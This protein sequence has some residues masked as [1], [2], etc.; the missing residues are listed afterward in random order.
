MSWLTYAIR[1]TMRTIFPSCV[2]G[3]PLAG[4]REDAVAD[5]VGEVEFPRDAERLLVV[6]EVAAEPLAQR[7]VERL[8][9][10]VAERR[11]PGVV[12]E[13]DRLDQILVQPQ[14][15][16]DDARDRGRLERVSHARPVMVALRVDEDLG[17][18]L[19][20]PER[21]RVDEAVAVALERRPDASTAP[22]P[23]RGRASRTSAPR[24]ATAST[25]SSARTRSGERFRDPA[26][27]LHRPA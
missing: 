1:S 3:L 27:D 2:S 19:E 26:R 4:V 18:P 21:L 6:Q 11:V 13:P 12:T 16:S 8:L 10:R 5:L 17:L 24:T 7:L 14:R 9:A 20:P 25:S 23:V 15:P 22:P